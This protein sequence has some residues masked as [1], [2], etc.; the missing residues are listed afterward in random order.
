MS[1]QRRK[2]DFEF[3]KQVVEAIEGGMSINEAARQNGISPSVILQ[4]RNKFRAGTLVDK[5]SARE[6]ALEKEVQKLHAEIGRLHMEIGHLKKLDAW[7][8]RR[9]K[10]DTSIITAKNLEEFQKGAES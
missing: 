3:K 1:K 10:L 8:Q 7:I 9:K 5:P 2:F 4:W 6:K